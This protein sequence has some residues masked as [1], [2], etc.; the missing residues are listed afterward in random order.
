[1]EFVFQILADLISPV[2]EKQVKSETNQMT[3][4]K[5]EESQAEKTVETT[6][7]EPNIFGMMDFH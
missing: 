2:D 3:E 5:K 6:T 4:N 1:M 7:E